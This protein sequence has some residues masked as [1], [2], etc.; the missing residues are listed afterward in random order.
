MAQSL[1]PR[2]FNFH[3]KTEMWFSRQTLTE[4]NTE[5]QSSLLWK[6]INKLLIVAFFKKESFR[7]P[8]DL[9]E[10]PADKQMMPD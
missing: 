10:Q 9:P 4:I 2:I 8:G 6:E 1:F 3:S 7:T 5:S